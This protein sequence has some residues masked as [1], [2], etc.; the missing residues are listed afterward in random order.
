MHRPMAQPACIARKVA[1][2]PFRMAN[3]KGSLGDR[4]RRSRLKA[5]LTL[6]Q[7]AKS[8]DVTGETIRLWE[9]GRHRPKAPMAMAWER[10]LCTLSV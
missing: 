6:A 10:A 9:C 5:G 2:S 8:L 4:M 1:Y 7:V 3:R